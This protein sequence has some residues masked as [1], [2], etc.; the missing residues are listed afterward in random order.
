MR[1][2]KR[3]FANLRASESTLSYFDWLRGYLD[4]HGCP[5]AFYPDKHTV[6]A[7]TGTPGLEKQ[8]ERITAK[9]Y[10]YPDRKFKIDWVPKTERLRFF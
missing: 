2:R 6:S 1:S 9:W 8:M 5:A 10:T 3:A 7:S 4:A